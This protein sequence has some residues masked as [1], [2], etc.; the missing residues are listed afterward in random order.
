MH[1]QLHT[2]ETL[3]LKNARSECEKLH[4]SLLAFAEENFIP[5]E[6][7]NDL[8]LAVEEAFINIIEYAY[9][10][11]KPHTITVEFSDTGN[12]ITTTFTDSGAAFDPLTDYGEMS[13]GSDHCEGGMGI[14]IIKSLT[15][16]QEYHRINQHNVFTI[17]KLYTKKK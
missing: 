11:N 4:Q 7:C 16:S 13:T 9:K 15:D 3:T 12:K 5:D 1:K 14:H 6:I 8:R 17:T 2:R 10:D